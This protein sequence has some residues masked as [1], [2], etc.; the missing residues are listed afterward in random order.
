MIDI[1]I[2]ILMTIFI[3]KDFNYFINILEAENT[4]FYILSLEVI[5]VLSSLSIVILTI[6]LM[7]KF[8][9]ITKEMNNQ[10]LDSNLMKTAK[11]AYMIS[12][13][14]ILVTIITQIL[15]NGWQLVF[16]AHLNNVAFTLN[17]PIFSIAFAL[18]GLLFYKYLGRVNELQEDHSMII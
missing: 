4:D 1:I 10:V 8:I 2:L 5:K 6:L 12:F 3:F 15:I 7:I 13:I 17:L 16:L 9:R 18:V 14:L 11:D